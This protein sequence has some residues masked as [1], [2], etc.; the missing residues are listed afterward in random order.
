MAMGTRKKRERQEPLWYGGELP[1]APGHPFYRRLTEI[2]DKAGFDQ[3]CEEACAKF[4]HVKLGR[5]SLAPGMYFRIMTVGFFEGLDSERGIAWRLADSLTLRQ[6]LSIGLHQTPD[7]RSDPSACLH[8]GAGTTGAE[9]ARQRKDYRRGFD[10]AGSECGDE[11]DRPA[12]Y[13]RKL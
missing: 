8:L 4:Y 1:E 5:P 6:F 2:L 11:V 10:H 9:R 3:F 7:R 13:G 12:R